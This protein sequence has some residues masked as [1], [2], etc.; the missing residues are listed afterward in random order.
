MKN[1]IT[2]QQQCSKT[3]MKFTLTT[4]SCSFLLYTKAIQRHKWTTLLLFIP[5]T[6]ENKDVP[7]CNCKLGK[8]FVS[9]FFKQLMIF[10]HI[11][12]FYHHPFILFHSAFKSLQ[13]GFTPSKSYRNECLATKS[14]VSNTYQL[15][16]HPHEPL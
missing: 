11:I 6:V 7:V 3:I 8:M 2:A 12:C 4:K 1:N 9:L 13:S 14:S 16:T 5:V 15:T 10:L